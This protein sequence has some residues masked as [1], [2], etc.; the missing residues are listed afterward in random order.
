MGCPFLHI[1]AFF[2]LDCIPNSQVAQRKI[3]KL[4]DNAALTE[5]VKFVILKVKKREDFF[6]TKYNPERR[7][8]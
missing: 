4:C 6:V 8:S 3:Q 2:A 5:K 7:K 1:V